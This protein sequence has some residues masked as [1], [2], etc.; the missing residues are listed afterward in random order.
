MP[1]LH[2][3]TSQVKCSY[4]STSSGADEY[5]FIIECSG[6]M[7]FPE[8][9][10]EIDGS[11]TNALSELGL[12]K[13]TQVFSRLY[14]SDIENQKEQ[15]AA[16]PLYRRLQRGA[17]SV[18]QQAS[19]IGGP[20]VLF[21]Y[22]IKNRDGSSFPKKHLKSENNSWRNGIVLKGHNYAMLWNALYA[23]GGEFDS[24]LQTDRIFRDLNDSIENHG[25]TLLGNGI[26]TWVHVRDIDNHYSGMVKAR[27]VF[28]AEK[29]LT[30]KSRY[31]ASTG[32]EGASIDTHSLVT[33]D[34]MSLSNCVPEQIVRM[35]ALD[36]L[37]PTID[38]GVTFERGLRVRFGDRSHLYI[39]GTAS[40]DN[41]GT[42]LH[43]SDIT[44]QT[45]RTLEN[46]KALLEPHGA[47]LSDMAYLFVYL[48][49]PHAIDIVRSIVQRHVPES[50][51]IL[52]T[53][54]AVCRPSW[55]VEME[56]VGIIR[57]DTPYPV[58]L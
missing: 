17:V 43:L 7:D 10:R 30:Q 55:L 8:A 52:Y 34:C 58:F 14:T 3:L 47:T 26:R 13:E 36:H 4:F 23:G 19:L 44:Q 24:Q 38:Y 21:S 20:I 27:R 31:L 50:I 54:A 57:D 29:D 37:S 35:E 49:D 39:S 48:R 6:H 41:K 12:S 22:H 33:V 42:V 40:I 32:I 28:F 5:T 56:G 25:M 53:Q 11:Y 18:I 51:P 15:L 2:S 9:L 46:M 16:S 1:E 45:R